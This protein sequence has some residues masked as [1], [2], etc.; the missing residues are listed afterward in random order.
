[1]D[2]MISFNCAAYG[3]FPMLFIVVKYAVT[4]SY[5]VPLSTPIEANFSPTVAS[6]PPGILSAWPNTNCSLSMS[7]MLAG[8]SRS[9]ATSR[10]HRMP[11]PKS[12]KTSEPY[13]LTWGRGRILMTTSVITPSV[14]SEPSTRWLKSGPQDTRGT[15]K[16]RSSTPLLVTILTRTSRSSMLPY[17]FFFMPEARVAT[18]PP[19]QATRFWR[20]IHS[21]RF[22]C[23]VS[24]AAIGRVSP[25]GQV[26][27]PDTDVPPPYGISTTLRLLA[28][29]TICSTCSWEVGNRTTSGMRLN[30][31]VRIMCTSCSV[32]PWHRIN[33]SSPFCVQSIPWPR[34]SARN[35]G[36]GTG[37]GYSFGTGT[38]SRR[39]DRSTLK[40][41]IT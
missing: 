35:S 4:G 6:G 1:M 13:R 27:E 16:L 30:V 20:S 40:F 31:P 8:C 26:T 15:A 33:R 14:P 36:Q 17:T 7:R 37:A 24:R 11:D 9:R 29:C 3:I 32:C 5:D 19:S 23:D 22:I 12:G 41:S 21:I 10:K 38:P 39:S 28:D 2:I 34:M 18:Q 25:S